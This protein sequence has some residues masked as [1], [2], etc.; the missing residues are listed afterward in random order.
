MPRSAVCRAPAPSDSKT[1]L[2]GPG[3]QGPGSGP[4]SSGMG[5]IDS[6]PV[7]VGP[8]L[9]GSGPSCVTG[10]ELDPSRGFDVPRCALLGLTP[11]VP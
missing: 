11:L 8:G 1:S 7:R 6:R 3:P 4:G 2:S 5:H 10:P 9:F